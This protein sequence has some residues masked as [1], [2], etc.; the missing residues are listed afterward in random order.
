MIDCIVHIL[1]LHTARCYFNITA[2]GLNSDISWEF[3]RSASSSI[4]AVAI[5]PS[6]THLLNHYRKD[7]EQKKDAYNMKPKVKEKTVPQLWKVPCLIMASAA[8]P[9]CAHVKN[10]IP[11]Q[12]LR[13]QLL[14]MG[15]RGEQLAARSVR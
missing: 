1:S 4:E 3:Q 13:H 6:V 8:A 12:S 2:D 9:M 7:H 5:K 15:F 10:D 11:F 14:L